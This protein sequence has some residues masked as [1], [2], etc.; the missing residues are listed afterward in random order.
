MLNGKILSSEYNML[1][2]PE[3]NGYLKVKEESEYQ[4]F[5]ILLKTWKKYKNAGFVYYFEENRRSVFFVFSV[6]NIEQYKAEA[7]KEEDHRRVE[8]TLIHNA[9]LCKDCC[10]NDADR[11]S[12]E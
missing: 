7:A 6:D 4:Y 12:H 5:Q 9:G 3:I 10:Q 8:C 1:E 11:N 2:I